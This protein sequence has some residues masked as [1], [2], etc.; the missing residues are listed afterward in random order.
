LTL[1]LISAVTILFFLCFTGPEGPIRA[2]RISGGAVNGKT[3]SW[4]RGPKRE[5]ATRGPHGQLRS[6]KPFR[7]R[8][9]YEIPTSSDG[10]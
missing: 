5:V 7:R 10:R 1:S 9:D 8:T 2:N 6:R 4:L 3:A